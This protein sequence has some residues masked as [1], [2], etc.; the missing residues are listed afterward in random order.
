MPSSPSPPGLESLSPSTAFTPF[1]VKLNSLLPE[2]LEHILSLVSTDYKERTRALYACCLVSKTVK[3]VVQPL[4]W[5]WVRLDKQKQVPSA[6][7]AG[8]RGESVRRFELSEVKHPV[9]DFPILSEK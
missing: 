2:L 4:L 6:L 8:R 3:D 9:L 5:R 1:P 7:A